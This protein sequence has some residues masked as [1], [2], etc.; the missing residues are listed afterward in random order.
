M[1]SFGSPTWQASLLSSAKQPSSRTKG[2]FGRAVASPIVPRLY[3]SD[4]TTACSVDTLERL[5]ITHIVTVLDI[6]PPFPEPVLARKRLHISIADR[7]DAKL[8]PH[9]DDTT[10]FIRDALAENDENKVLVHCFMGVSRSASVVCAYLIATRDMSATSAI[11]FVKSKRG[12]VCPNTGFTL[13]LEQY[14]MEFVKGNGP[15]ATISES[16]AGRIRKL[17]DAAGLA[18]MHHAS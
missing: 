14:A 2:N 16:I 6:E 10:A 8:L 5:G 18:H 12:I 1:L 11:A 4:L 9:L 15:R 17:K 13:Q 7:P 3:L